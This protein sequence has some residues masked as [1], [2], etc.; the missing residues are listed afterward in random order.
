Q[1]QLEQVEGQACF[2]ERLA[3]PQTQELRDAAQQRAAGEAAASEREAGLAEE[4]EAEQLRLRHVCRVARCQP[5]RRLAHGAADIDV[6][7]D[8]TTALVDDRAG[9]RDLERWIQLL[10]AEEAQPRIA[11][12]ELAQHRACRERIRPALALQLTE[13][14][15]D[16]ALLV[17]EERAPELRARLVVDHHPRVRI[18]LHAQ[19]A[20]RQVSEQRVRGWRERIIE[21]LAGRKEQRFVERRL[22]DLRDLHGAVGHTD[23]PREQQA[24]ERAGKR[25]RASELRIRLVVDAHDL[26]VVQRH[27]EVEHGLAERLQCDIAR[28]HGSAV[29]AR[30]PRVDDDAVAGKRELPLDFGV[31]FVERGERRRALNDLCAAFELR[32]VDGSANRDRPGYVALQIE[33]AAEQRLEWCEQDAV[34]DD[35]SAH[36]ARLAHPDAERVPHVGALWQCELDVDHARRIELGLRGRHERSVAELDVALEAG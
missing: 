24:V 4:Q 29:R 1:P 3:D 5:Q 21:C 30:T 27:C 16:I 17:Y 31:A 28:N 22:R 7:L 33:H 15:P 8:G 6:D 23:V 34:R 20:D 35:A 13:Y 12:L 36:T 9:S 32:V 14:A 25:K 18:H 19:V 10:V 11:D 2:R 26:E